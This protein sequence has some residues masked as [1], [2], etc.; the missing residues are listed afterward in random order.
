MLPGSP[1][2]QDFQSPLPGFCSGP[3][4]PKLVIVTFT[5]KTTLLRPRTIVC[6][7]SQTSTDCTTSL[8][9]Q[10]FV[11]ARRQLQ[12]GLK[13]NLRYLG[14][15]PAQN[16]RLLVTYHIRAKPRLPRPVVDALVLHGPEI[17]TIFAY[18]GKPAKMW[19][20]IPPSRELS[21]V[22]QY[23]FKSSAFTI[24]QQKC[25]IHGRWL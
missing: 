18:P 21:Q 8:C 9:M 3:W 22:P 13:W 6:Q 16:L 17:Q 11:I 20:F 1:L 14:R 2:V 5:I 10:Y 12:Y 7:V 15:M 24:L 23:L 4:E 25:D 19:S